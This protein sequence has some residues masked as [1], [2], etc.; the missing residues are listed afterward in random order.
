MDFNKIF[1]YL[2]FLFFLCNVSFAGKIIF[3]Q[4]AK[5]TSIPAEEFTEPKTG[6]VFVKIPGGC[7]KMGHEK[8]ESPVHE[9][10][11][12]SFWISKYEVTNRQYRWYDSD[13]KSFQKDYNDSPLVDLDDDEKPVVNVSHKD[14]VHFTKWLMLPPKAS[15]A[16]TKSFW[17]SLKTFRLPTEAEWEYVARGGETFKRYLNSEGVAVCSFGNFS[18]KKTHAAVYG[19]ESEFDGVDCEDRYSSTAPVGSFIP[20]QYGVYDMLGNVS[21]WVYDAMDYEYYKKSPRTNPDGPSSFLAKRY[22]VRGGNWLNWHSSSIY[23]KKENYLLL[24]GV[25]NR[26]AEKP[27]LKRPMLGFRVVMKVKPNE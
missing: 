22:V 3:P 1:I 8:I 21:E 9:V 5:D 24:T 16:F 20:N 26:N 2:F 12:D 4:Y 11:I 14:A 23:W 6:I 25:F 13:H 17:N 19:A 27:T 10:C 15:D 18:G 7:F